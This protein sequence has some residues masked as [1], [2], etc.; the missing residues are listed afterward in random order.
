MTRSRNLN[1]AIP[2]IQLYDV[3]GN[4][5]LNGG[6]FHTWDTQ[7]FRTSNFT[8]VTDSTKIIL[9]RHGTGYYKITFE[10]SFFSYEETDIEI[11]TKIYKNGSSM[12]G[13]NTLATVQGDGA[14][15]MNIATSISLTF[16]LLLQKG[17]YIQIYS[18]PTG[19]GAYT[20]ANSS[21]LTVEFIPMRGWDND[22][23]GL[24]SF[25]GGVE[26]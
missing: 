22:R 15:S 12:A 10:C 24:E 25:R 23:G 19:N 13:T 2:A 16:I 20:Y 4:Q 14:Q 11:L 3:G 7:S 8:Y 21:R 5:L 18:L 6:V 1:P 26:R 17:D 9:N